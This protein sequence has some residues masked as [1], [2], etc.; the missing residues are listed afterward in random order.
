MSQSCNGLARAVRAREPEDLT[1]A[2]L[3]ADPAHGLDRAALAPEALAQ[4]ARRDFCQPDVQLSLS[5]S[6]MVAWAIS[7]R[8]AADNVTG[9]PRP[10]RARAPAA[11]DP[12]VPR[13]PGNASATPSAPGRP[14]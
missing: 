6:Q 13:P 9:C 10:A 4:V 1:L 2:D 5:A 7:V 11:P 14:C 12:G 8:R 3:E